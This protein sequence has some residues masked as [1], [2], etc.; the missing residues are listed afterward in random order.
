MSESSS[1]AQ[2]SNTKKC[3][4]CHLIKQKQVFL[5]CCDDNPQYEY[6]TCNL[7]N[8]RRSKK[9][10]EVNQTNKIQTET[11][12]NII[13]LTV[14]TSRT[15]A[16]DFLQIKNILRDHEFRN[17]EL[18]DEPVKF[19]F[20]IELD[21]G[22][23]NAVA[24]NYDLKTDSFNLEQIKNNF[25]QLIKILILPLESGII[26]SEANYVKDPIV[27]SNSSNLQNISVITQENQIEKRQEQYIYYAKKFEK[28][29][30]LYKREI[31]NDNFVK[32]FD[33]LVRPFVKAVG[34]CE[35]VLQARN[36]QGTQ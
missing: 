19:A 36:Q 16:S 10:K 7:Y 14:S 35:E 4:T 21:L 6:D 20:E 15:N 9:R 29:L 1:S 24:L 12:L 31:D 3:S 13:V 23:L 2:I 33:T 25:I 26:T 8:T 11:G 32:N 34:E 27:K 18:F 17:A 5:R 22:L 28:A 30:E